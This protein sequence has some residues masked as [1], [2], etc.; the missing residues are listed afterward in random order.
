MSQSELLRRHEG[1][2][3]RIFLHQN[4]KNANCRLT[5]MIRQN[6]KVQLNNF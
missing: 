4:Q 2:E 1:N 5:E 3:D 6:I